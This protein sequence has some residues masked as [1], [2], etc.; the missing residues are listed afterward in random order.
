MFTIAKIKQNV[1]RTRDSI[2]DTSVLAIQLTSDILVEENR[3]QL[4]DGKDRLGR[5]ITPSYLDDPYFKSRESA[6]RYSDWKDTITPNPNR[7]K[8]T[9]N[10]YI[11]GTYHKSIKIDVSG[12]SIIYKA[13]FRGPEIEAKY[14]EN[15]YGLGGSRRLKYTEGVLKPV[16]VRL[17][18]EKIQL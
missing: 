10:L 15:I 14:G 6:Q 7:T 2:E 9:P 13:S 4:Y 8:G 1:T 16:L 12:T 11:V 18:K 17:L 3:D 5:D